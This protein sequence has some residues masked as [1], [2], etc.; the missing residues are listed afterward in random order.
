MECR[1][2]TWSSI[3]KPIVTGNAT[4][5]LTIYGS[6]MLNS[7]STWNYK[8]DIHLK[9]SVSGNIINTYGKLLNGNISFEGTGSWMLD[10]SLLLSPSATL[11]LSSGSLIANN[12]AIQCGTLKISGSSQKLL[13]INHSLLAI[14]QAYDDIGAGNFH[15]NTT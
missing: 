14:K 10:G 3:L 2:L 7:Q 9:S 1:N 15:S 8:G 13:D 5:S 11:T 12:N 4:S 6:L